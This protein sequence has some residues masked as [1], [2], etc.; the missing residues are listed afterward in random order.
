MSRNRAVLG[1]ALAV[2]AL[3]VVLFLSNPRDDP[4]HRPFLDPRG[5]GPEGTAAL[6]ALL[7]DLG[8]DV[9][10]G[11]L[12]GD[13]DVALVLR[14]TLSGAPAGELADWV[15][16]GGTLVVAD[17]FASLAAPTRPTE[18]FVSARTEPGTCTLDALADVGRIEP[19]LPPVLDATEGTSCFGDGTAAGLVARTHGD[20]IV[21][22]LAGP[23]QLVNE[24]LGRAD[25]AVLAT[26]LIL[27]HP[28]AR[29][30]VLDPGQLMGDE[31]EI[32]DGTVLG[33]LPLRGSQAVAQL[34]IAFLACGLILGRRLGRPV[35]EEMPV[36]L[37]ASDLV[38]ASGALLDRNGD[39]ADAA[40]RLRRRTRRDLGLV[41]GLGADPPP[42][43]LA[44][45][46]ASRAG[47]DP[48]LVRSALLTPVV[49]EAGLVRTA[50]LLDRLRTE[51]TP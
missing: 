42:D 8:G 47:V 37:P 48:A 17:P 39:V 19:G 27:P 7:R 24:N 15:D 3:V 22:T 5:T 25:D 33:A 11:G 28:G 13:D 51:L 12:P 23:E 2:L 46:L 21:V 10:I 4:Y 30:R 16:G 40:E 34:V 38:L 45:A 18:G 31:E 44:D 1:G 50:T 26:A 14:D 9:R 41:L 43:Q 36:P 32:G 6:V 20:G 49:D 35:V 29:V